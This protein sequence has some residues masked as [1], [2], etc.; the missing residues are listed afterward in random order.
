[1]GGYQMNMK[2]FFVF[3]SALFVCVVSSSQ[4]KSPER[5]NNTAL[6]IAIGLNKVDPKYYEG[7]EG[8]LIACENDAADMLSIA[9]AQGYETVPLKTAEATKKRVRDA[10]TAAAARLKTGDTLVISYSG[11]GGQV[12]D[13]N[14]DE[15]DDGLDETWCLFDGEI[16]DDELALLWT[17]FQPG[18][19]IVVYSDSCHSGTV[20]KK[21]EE[22]GV[23]ETERFR[24]M[25]TAVAETLRKLPTHQDL[26]KGLPSE[27]N[28]RS[29]TKA[30]V[31]LISAC[32]DNQLSRDGDKNGLFTGT[33]IQA[34]KNG[35][36]KGSYR[37]FYGAI[38]K[39]MPVYQKPNFDTTGVSNPA[40]EV[41]RP[42]SHG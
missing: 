17:K 34:W 6:A 9:R 20:I 2:S 8:P 12:R 27:I 30:S 37:Q 23:A 16:V 24:I 3:V 36:F 38:R 11:H 7:W 4:T 33:L 32:Q 28:S 19:R 15:K 25:P 31:L 35:A 21:F 41:E 22:G 39:A 29:H 1:M 18:V 13:T 10:I 26:D 42:W 5:F 40:F 14:G